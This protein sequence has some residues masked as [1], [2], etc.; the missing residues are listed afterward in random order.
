M[1]EQN[2]ENRIVLKIE[3][4]TKRFGG[5]VAVNELNINVEQ[6]NICAL[7]GPN[8][9]GKTT[10]LNL[11]T[12]IYPINGG[13][14]EFLGEP[15]QGLP[16][17]SVCWRGIARTFQNIRILGSQ[18]V[19]EN[20]LLG[21]GYGKGGAGIFHTVL[22]TPRYRKDMAESTDEVNEILEFAGLTELRRERACNLPYGK[23][24]ILEIARALVTKPKLLLLD[25][26]AAGLNSQEIYTLMELISKI[27][28]RGISI[29]LIE[30]RMEFIGKLADWVFVLNHGSKIAEGTFDVIKENPDVIQAYLGRGGRKLA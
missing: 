4:L 27:N 18:T 28:E 15:I 22:N 25:E 12:G 29:L 17:H 16:P 6:G 8:G 3:G 24:R 21:K 2:Q 7:I 23:Q 10:V 1:A 26:P 20:A 19:F 5:L 13:K 11:I 9:S 14:I 30:H